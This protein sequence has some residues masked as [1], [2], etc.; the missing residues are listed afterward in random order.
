MTEHEKWKEEIDDFIENRMLTKKDCY[1]AMVF[2]LVV[3][4][5]IMICV[6]LLIS[7]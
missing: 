5:L 6:K 1:W 2:G 4:T 7:T 3:M